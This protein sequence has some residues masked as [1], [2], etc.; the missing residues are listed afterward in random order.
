MMFDEGRGVRSPL[1]WNITD[2]MGFLS[3]GFRIS[4]V[5]ARRAILDGSW[6]RSLDA[7]KELR[8]GREKERR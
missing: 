3:S 1:S 5:I 8:V 7:I 6:V 4:R 2:M